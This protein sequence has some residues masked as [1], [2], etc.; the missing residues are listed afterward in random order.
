MASLQ[1]ITVLQDF[2][3]KVGLPQGLA[4]RWSSIDNPSFPTKALA[5]EDNHGTGLNRR[6]N[7]VLGLLGCDGTQSIYPT[8]RSHRQSAVLVKLAPH[9]GLVANNWV[10]GWPYEFFLS[11]VLPPILPRPQV[12]GKVYPDY[13]FIT[14]V[15][16]WADSTSR[17]DHFHQPHSPNTY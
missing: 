6:T 14:S 8:P 11:Q 7:G 1:L 5:G 4:Y 12:L 2:H 17:W 13:T 9:H 3:Q 10:V 16:K 15:A